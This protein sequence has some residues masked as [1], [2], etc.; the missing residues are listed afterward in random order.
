MTNGPLTAAERVDVHFR[1]HYG[2]GLDEYELTD[3]PGYWRRLEPCGGRGK[4]TSV[5]YHASMFCEKPVRHTG[6]YYD[7]GRDPVTGRWLSPYRTWQELREMSRHVREA[8]EGIDLT[9][10]QAA[11]VLR[12]SPLLLKA[13]ENGTASPGPEMLERLGRLYRR[14]AAW[15]TG[16]SQLIPSPGTLQR[17]EGPHPSSRGAAPGPA[18]FP[19]EAGHPP[20]PGCKTGARDRHA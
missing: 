14:P 20:R 11:A 7:G 1:T 17:T 8:R 19:Q 15:F 9:R 2:R 5:E 4:C 6:S 13:M 16:E 10:D 12:C 3:T 18:G